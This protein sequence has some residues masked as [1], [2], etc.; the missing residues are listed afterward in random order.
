M[1]W[2]PLKNHYLRAEKVPESST[3]PQSAEIHSGSMKRIFMFF[4][5]QNT[6]GKRTRVIALFTL[7][8]GSKI[9]GSKRREREL[10]GMVLRR[11]S[12]NG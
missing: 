3:V 10:T 2:F 5:F 6:N 11:R 7:I 1:I 9:Y 8:H 4:T 12:H